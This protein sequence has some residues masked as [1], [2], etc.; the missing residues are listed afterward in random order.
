MDF[1]KSIIASKGAEMAAPLVA[2]L[3][4][5]ESQANMFLPVAVKAIMGKVMGEDKNE[6]SSFSLGSLLGDGGPDL[7]SIMGLI[8]PGEVAKEAG[9]SES[10]AKSGLESIGPSLM[11]GLKEQGAGAIMGALGGGDDA[12]GLL[13]AA[14]KLAGGLFK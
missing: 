13:G 12:G 3:G 8:N 6:A 9:V 7:S 2:K 11:D 4:F 10:L 1:I 14:G 5:S